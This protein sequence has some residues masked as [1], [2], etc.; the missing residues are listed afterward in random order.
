MT[1]IGESS[2][3]HCRCAGCVEIIV[4]ND[5]N[6]HAA[7]TN[8]PDDAYC[9]ECYEAGCYNDTHCQAQNDDEHP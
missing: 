1:G 4:V 7:G 3:A 5:I 9:E 8:P 2:Y 6:A